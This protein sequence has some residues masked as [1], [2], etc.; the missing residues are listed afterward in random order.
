MT[1]F[2][3][4]GDAY[5]VVLCALDAARRLND[6]NPVNADEAILKKLQVAA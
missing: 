1:A 3:M 6:Q 4:D 2:F 5:L